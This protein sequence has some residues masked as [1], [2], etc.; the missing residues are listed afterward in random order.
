VD[1]EKKCPYCNAKRVKHGTTRN[2]MTRFRCTGC[3]K[4]QVRLYTYTAYSGHINPDIVSL[5]KE[6]LGIRSTAI[7]LGISA[8]TVRKRIILISGAIK[9]PVI[10]NGKIYEVDELRTFIK[11]KD[12]MVWIVCALERESKR[13][14]SFH[15]GPRTNKT[16]NVVLKSL[17]LSSATKICTD[18]LKNYKY[19]INAA[20][21]DARRYATNH[22]ERFNLTLRTHLKR[23]KRRTICFSR[24]LVLL[25]AILKIYFFL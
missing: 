23:L 12:K 7:F 24:S 25:N 8:T 4:T 5:T 6:G 19:L 18:G 17:K 15:T 16:L 9:L 3:G 20:V 10:A 14:V 21:H 1:F 13:I 22:I 11:R 2:G